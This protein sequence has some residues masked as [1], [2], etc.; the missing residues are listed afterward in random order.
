MTMYSTK[1]QFEVAS[2]KTVTVGRRVKLSGADNK[3]EDAGVGDIGIGIA[4]TGGAAG[5]KVLIVLDGPI[6]P[7]VVGTGGAT[8]GKLAKMIAD[9]FTD[10]TPAGAGTTLVYPAGV[11]L[12]SG[13]A[14]DKVGMIHA[15]TVVTE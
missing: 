12:Q 3:V 13:V 7:V 8:R 2:A 5:A 11:F 9:G 1:K 10:V 14:G 15:P 4:E 6:V